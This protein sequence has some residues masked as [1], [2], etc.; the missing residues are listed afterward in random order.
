MRMKLSSALTGLAMGALLLGF[1]SNASAEGIEA[2]GNIDVE[3]NA[4]CRVEADCSLQ[5]KPLSLQASCAAEL[6]VMCSGQC[7]AQAE[8]SCTGSCQA[9][10]EGSCMVD[11]PSF[12][13]EGECSASCN[14]DCS[15]Q[16]SGETTADGAR[17]RC[18]A[19]CKANCSSSC[20]AS[21]QGTPGS[22]NCQAK[23]Q[24]S[25]QG[26]CR[27]EAN[28]ECQVDCQ[29][30]GYASCQAELQGGCEGACSGD[31]A[32]FCDGQYVDHGNNLQDCIDA[33]RAELNITASG[34]AQCS[35]NS[36]TAEGEAEASCGVARLPSRGS[37]A[38]IAGLVGL[39][40]FAARRRRS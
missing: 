4:E 38:W 37:M 22:A 30:S 6:Q 18:E 13:C 39:G 32:L 23:C 1:A 12:E 8:V 25:C 14:A 17:G 21:C 3:A 11:P 28:A 19:S 10:C 33:L 35:G 36:C 27:A 29:S 15:G 7:T 2:C 16:C 5:C 31:G 26:E 40:A 9:D 20:Q 24:A 34:S